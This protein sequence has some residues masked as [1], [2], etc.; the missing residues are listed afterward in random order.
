MKQ[1]RIPGIIAVLIQLIASVCFMVLLYQTK[2]IPN[3]LLLI[4]GG[5]LLFITLIVLLLTIDFKHRGRFF[6][7]VLLIFAILVVYVLSGSYVIKGV[8]TLTNITK[9]TTVERAGIGIYVREDDPAASVE[10]TAGYH[11]GIL[12]ELNL[13]IQIWRLKR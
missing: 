10:D 4:I 13:K 5:V 1:K 3:K 8:K 12:E 9:K 6:A 7:G 11:F 2:L